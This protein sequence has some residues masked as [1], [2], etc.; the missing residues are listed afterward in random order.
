MTSPPTLFALCD[1]PRPVPAEGLPDGLAYQADI[2][3]PDE[4]A[5]LVAEIAGLP[6]AKFR[7]HGQE[8]ERR[9]V[10]F[11]WAYDFV[12]RRLD[13]APPIPPFLL[14]LRAKVAA[15]AGL[16]PDAFEQAIALEY[17]PGAGI[18]WHKDRPQFECVA[19]VS[20]LASC[21]FRFRRR[22]D[23]G[24]ARATLRP[25]PRSAYVLAGE[26]RDAWEHS[27]PP[28]DALRYSVTFRNF[29]PEARAALAAPQLGRAP[30]AN[31]TG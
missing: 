17:Q 21:P 20:L 13:P 10:S 23:E 26:A 30:A 6:F 12:R 25:A 4:E 24:W 1:A 14:P 27:I 22:T 5:Q 9:I 3:G 16:E 11:G 28:L 18:G 29:R 2:I 7:F 31:T 15:L 8:A 19:G